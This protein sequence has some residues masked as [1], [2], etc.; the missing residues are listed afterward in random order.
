MQASPSSP[1]FVGIDV[2]KDRLDVHLWPSGEA[3]SLPHNADGLED[4]ATRL[5]GLAPELIVLE[6]TGGFEVA[7]ALA[8]AGLRLA[9]VNPRQIRAFARAIG[10]LAKTD[11][12]DAEVIALFAERVRP[13]ARAIPNAQV[14]ALADLVARRR[15]IIDMITAESNRQRQT[16][17]R[18]LQSSLERH[19]AW[20][21]HELRGIDRDLEGTVRGTPAWRETED[22][23]AS[24]PGIGPITARTLIAELPELGLLDRRRIAALVGVAPINRD[25]GAMRGR[26]MIMGGR[27]T[28]RNALFMA[29]VSA[30]QWNPSIRVFYQRLIQAGRPAKIARV[31][32]MRKLL[33]IL[34][35]VLRDRHPWKVA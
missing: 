9:V 6:A 33:T 14:R 16:H 11:R 15:Q 29:T 7:A 13:E 26:R 27:T 20:L 24:V 12:L 32:C 23:L 35:A 34:N 10:R 4:L 19:L 22:L 30:T 3:F 5:V 31:A 2:S 21:Q 8:G 1:V 28:V 17:D 25:S 18:R